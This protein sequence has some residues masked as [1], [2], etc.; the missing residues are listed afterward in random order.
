MR[1]CM[2]CLAGPSPFS[3]VPRTPQRVWWRGRANRTTSRLYCMARPHH[4]LRIRESI[5]YKILI[6][7]YRAHNGSGPGHLAELIQPYRPGRKLRSANENKLLTSRISIASFGSRRFAVAGQTLRNSFPQALRDAD[8]LSQFKRLLKTYLFTR[9]YDAWSHVVLLC[10]Y[11]V[12]DT[13]TTD[14]LLSMS[15]PSNSYLISVWVCVQRRESLW[16]RDPT[17][18]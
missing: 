10:F 3:R 9:S 11:L 14:S 1:F 4:W 18:L 13:F 8:S 2:V 5:A 17:A 15:K 16:E 7:L 6:M 12:T